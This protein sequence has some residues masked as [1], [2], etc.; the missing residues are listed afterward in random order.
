MSDQLLNKTGIPFPSEEDGEVVLIDSFMA[1][2]VD[3]ETA[4]AAISEIKRLRRVNENLVIQLG[5]Y[6]HSVLGDLKREQETLQQQGKGLEGEEVLRKEVQS[7]KGRIAALEKERASLANY[8]EVEQS[9]AVKY[10][11]ERDEYNEV[12]GVALDGVGY[13]LQKRVCFNADEYRSYIDLLRKAHEKKGVEDFIAF[14][15]AHDRV[16]GSSALFIHTLGVAYSKEI[17]AEDG[18]EVCVDMA[19]VEHQKLA[20]VVELIDMTADRNRERR[21]ADGLQAQISEIVS[22]VLMLKENLKHP[23]ETVFNGYYGNQTCLYCRESLG[24]VIAKAT[25]HWQGCPAVPVNQIPK[26]VEDYAEQAKSKKI[27]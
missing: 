16:D 3:G 5:K 26:W 24:N 19:N 2:Q 20:G 8:G 18:V 17:D 4:G 11:A 21:R 25:E 1:G 15:K 14:S 27:E 23:I 6:D 9:R 13:P 12:A 7:L 10:K 22:V